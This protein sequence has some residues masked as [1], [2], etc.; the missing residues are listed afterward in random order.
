MVGGV[1][2]APL[3]PAGALAGGAAGAS[4]GESIYQLGQHFAGSPEAP[5]SPQEAASR[6]TGALLTGGL[7]EVGP[8]MAGP[9]ARKMQAGAAKNIIQAVEPSG[10]AAKEAVQK[11]APKAVGEFPVSFSAA[12]LRRNLGDLSTK[13][14]TAVNRAYQSVARRFPNTQFSSQPLIQ[15]LEKERDQAML[16][17]SA[18]VGQESKVKAY[19]TVIDWLRNNPR[20]KISDFRRIKQNW[21]EVVNWNKFSESSAKD[22]VM[23]DA[24]EVASNRVR[25]TI[26]QTFPSLAKAD[27]ESH[28]WS[29]LH[30]AAKTSDIRS[31]TDEWSKSLLRR[32]GIAGAAGAGVEYARGGNPIVGMAGGAALAYAPQTVLWDTLSAAGKARVGQFLSSPAGQNTLRGLSATGS[33]ALQELLRSGQAPT[34]PPKS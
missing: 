31:V 30:R 16:G 7:Q 10:M 15:S 32:Y 19:N 23:A 11:A 34:P 6:Q 17:G 33:A 22:P 24:L 3:G 8:A 27:A 9:V 2:G 12:G 26:H 13:A 4:I 25:D 29:T 21:D 18:I 1:T 5:Q 20:F 14:N 28:L